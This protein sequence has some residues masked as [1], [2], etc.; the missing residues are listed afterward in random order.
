MP[1]VVPDAI[2]LVNRTFDLLEATY[3]KMDKLVRIKSAVSHSSG[4][5]G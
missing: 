2:E 1:S 4:I 5:D 3:P